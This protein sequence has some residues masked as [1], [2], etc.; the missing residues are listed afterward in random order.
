M[1]DNNEQN[2]VERAKQG[3]SAAV[4]ELFRRYWRAARATA[5]GVTGDLSLAEDAASDALYAAFKGLQ[6]LKDNQRFAP[7]LR[8][9]VV[10]TARHLMTS[11]SKKKSVEL[12]TLPD[13]Q[14]Q[15]PSANL[16]QHE[17]ITLIHEAVAN[18]SETLREAIS[19]FYFENYSIEEAARF[20]DIPPGT[21][22]RRLHDGRH[23]LKNAAEQIL[24]GKK[25]INLHR[26]N[27][28]RQFKELID[29]GLDSMDSRQVLQ[30]V[31]KLRPL[32]Y[33]L[34][35]KF[36]K[37]HS[38]TAKKMA[39]PKGHQEMLCKA[40]QMYDRIYQPSQRVLDPDH[41]VGNV[42]RAIR[43]AL[44]EFREWHIDPSKAARK[45]VQIVSGNFESL[46][47][48]PGFNKGTPGSYTYTTRGSLV[49]TEDGSMHTMY[50]LMQNKDVKDLKDKEF[51]SNG[52]LSDVLALMWMK[53]GPIE[54]SVVEKL[55]RRLSNAIVPQINARFLPYEEPR[56][57]TA[58]RMQFGNIPVPAAIGGPLNPWPNMP[59]G[60]TAAGVQIYLESWATAQTGQVIELAELSELLNMIIDKPEQHE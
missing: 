17:L 41:A 58:L 32:P 46:N 11:R 37:Q 48:P 13:A 44:P 39:T 1:K 27:I 16:E 43:T 60:L 4:A 40:R 10:R 31:L 55:L 15:S 20:L 59:Q 28:L 21:F 49:Q 24:K 26:E 52:R 56:Y 22:K 14:P 7:W 9:I 53:S 2:W 35:S 54:L 12:K 19:L 8:T 38:N 45:L 51:I 47:L 29:K 34:M 5:Y 33:E 23:R 42:A 3:D 57:R 6:S 18:L 36:L 30:Q 25:P 50:E